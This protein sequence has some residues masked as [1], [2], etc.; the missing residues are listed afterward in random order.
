MGQ[1][2][3]ATINRS[4]GASV[5]NTSSLNMDVDDK[6]TLSYSLSMSRASYEH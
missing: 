6:E 4:C 3:G 5:D 2:T 1:T